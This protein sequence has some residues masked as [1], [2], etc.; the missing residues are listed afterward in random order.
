M[1]FCNFTFTIMTYRD[2]KDY[3]RNDYVSN[4]AWRAE[5]EFSGEVFAIDYAEY[6]EVGD[7]LYVLEEYLDEYNEEQKEETED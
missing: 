3:F 6:T 4:D 2:L 7:G 1:H 5:C